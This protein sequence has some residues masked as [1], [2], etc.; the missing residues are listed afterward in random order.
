MSNLKE[1]WY[2]DQYVGHPK[3]GNVYRNFFIAKELIK[4]GY[5]VRIFSA[6][7]SHLM[8]Q[9]PKIKGLITTEIIDGVEFNWIKVSKYGEGISIKRFISIFQF[10]FRIWS[11]RKSPPPH[12]IVT[13]SVPF[14]PYWPIFYLIKIKWKFKK[15]KLILEIRDLWPLT[16]T[17]VGKISKFNPFIILLAIT[18]KHALKNVDYI[19]ST[20]KM[21]NRYIDKIISSPYR[22]KWIDN[23]INI[24]ESSEVV[25]LDVSIE[26]LIPNKKFIVGYAGTLARATSIEYLIDAARLMS[27]NEDIHFVI[28]GD[29]YEKNN[30]MK[31]ALDL[32]NITFIPRIN[33]SLIPSV[34]QKFNVLYYS[35]LNNTELYQY[36]VSAN[37]TYEYMLSGK[38]II[39]SA[40]FMEYNIISNARCGIV[41]P[42]ESAKEIA[43]AIKLLSSKSREELNEMGSRGRNYVLTYNTFDVLAGRLVAVFNELDIK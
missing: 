39:L 22:Y 2:V 30:L 10:T 5:K 24:V 33:K 1:V 41:V 23:G 4:K 16:F 35:H 13:P 37:K 3:Y 19:I 8:Y 9:I 20:L 14:L 28:V 32:S 36:G 29:G 18:E 26:Q 34:L 43:G 6:S 27:E 31:R 25:E 42:P 38:P 11:L 40:P 15:P 12:I 21:C 17:T 7:F